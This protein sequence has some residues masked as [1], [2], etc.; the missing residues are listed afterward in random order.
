MPGAAG[1]RG[2]YR[3]KQR[4]KMAETRTAQHAAA[5]GFTPRLHELGFGYADPASH[6]A[7]DP[8]YNSAGAFAGSSRDPE[9]V[10]PPLWCQ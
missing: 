6:S 9:P 8:M 5:R 10:S 4:A 1:A 7:S 3:K 2:A